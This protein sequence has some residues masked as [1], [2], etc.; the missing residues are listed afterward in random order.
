MKTNTKTRDS[1]GGLVPGLRSLA[2]RMIPASGSQWWRRGRTLLLLTLCLPGLALVPPPG[3]PAPT[4]ITF[5]ILQTNCEDSPLSYEFFLNSTSLGTVTGVENEC[6]CTPPLQTFIVSDAELLAAAW[7]AEGSN[8][9]RFVK[10]YGYYFSW[11]RAT[12]NFPDGPKTFYYDTRGGDATDENLC[13]GYTSDPL[14]VQLGKNYYRDADGDGLGNPSELIF[15]VSASPPAGYVTNNADCDDS[16]PSVTDSCHQPFDNLAAGFTQELV[17]SLPDNTQSSGYAF[18]SQGNVYVDSFDNGHLYKIDLSTT[19]PLPS[20]IG[21]TYLV[22]D[23]GPLTYRSG[24]RT[25]ETTSG[26]NFTQYPDGTV[27]LNSWTGLGVVRVDLATASITSDPIPDAPSGNWG[28]VVDPQLNS[29]GHHSIWYQA[30]GGMSVVDPLD[31]RYLG[32]IPIGT[33]G[34][35][36]DPTGNYI[37]TTQ[38]GM[39]VSQRV[40]SSPETPD[41]PVFQ[42][43]QYA[44][45]NGQGGSPDGMAFGTIGNKKVVVTN[46]GNGETLSMY[47]FPN[48]DFSQPM[49]RTVIA[50][51]TYPGEYGDQ[52][53]VGPDGYFYI[54]YWRGTRFPDGTT[55]GNASVVRIGPAGRFLPATHSDNISLAPASDSKPQGA[56]EVLTATLVQL[57]LE[58]QETVPVVGTSVTFT[59]VGGPDL[60][61]TF[62]GQTDTNGQVMFTLSNENGPG[63]DVVHAQFVDSNHNT[64]TSNNSVTTFAENKP[65]VAKCKNMT[66]SA[67]A[68]CKADASI[69]DGSFD[70]DSGDTITVTQDPPG[71]YSLGDTSV[72]LTV[73]DSHDASSSCTST[74]TVKD[75]TAPVFS[76]C[77]ENIV[78]QT[79]PGRTTCDQVARWTPPTATD[80][81]A[82]TLTSNYESGATFPVG[83]TTV[84]YTAVDGATTANRSTCSFTVTVEDNTPPP[85]PVLVDVTGECSAT[86]TVPTAT[87]NCA[88]TVTGT[89]S[90]PLTY[91]AQGTYTVHWT[92]DDGR[93]NSSTA[94][95]NVIVKDV[96]VPLI[97]NCP[98]NI[99]VQTGLGRTTCDQVASWTPPTAGDN[100]TLASFTSNHH[101]GD[102]FPNGITTV[103]YTARD[104]AI[105]PNISACSFT[106]TVEDRTLPVITCPA[107][108]VVNAECQTG[109]TVTYTAPTATDNCSIASIVNVGLA[110][111]SLFPIG[112]S[113]ITSTATDSSNNRATCSFIIHVNGPEEQLNDLIRLVNGLP[114]NSRTK[115]RWVR[116]L[117]EVQSH[118]LMSKIS[119]DELSKFMGVVQKAKKLTP[120]QAAQL[121]DAATRIQA[122]TGCQPGTTC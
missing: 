80:C 115:Q 57:D 73:K 98:A 17:A 68:N 96:S 40:A 23:L 81:S 117:N 104:G 33:D 10:S 116:Q 109:A 30:G 31:Q 78:V 120:T 1:F 46:D 20:G 107:S 114:L 118:G 119:C 87:D 89:T 100:C 49:T 47:E 55:N 12:L 3:N 77:P 61:Q 67:G 58:T 4:Q 76:G 50:S 19:V 92:F 6:T 90:D 5:E 8:S 108:K 66:V 106:V 75:T 44:N 103:T 42:H 65:P 37:F 85:A 24:A 102:T 122:V 26:G 88:G 93:H 79:G 16:D 72:T 9:L 18:D 34:F 28:I 97:S 51:G 91:D 56:S 105:P 99:T 43:V 53:N 83:I 29:H 121:R 11:V 48:N 21:R 69:D 86:V 62:T 22:T 13:A 25:G 60:G 41:L 63:D 59:V 7:N 36:V 35:A 14:D 45:D 2:A 52:A 27:Y 39:E 71:P 64:Q 111:G 95:Q 82:V 112:D 70:P 38:G 15:A 54:T 32:D 74:V 101:S 113:T 110:S 84:T 94:N